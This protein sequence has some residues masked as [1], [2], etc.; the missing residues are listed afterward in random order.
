MSSTR[1]QRL[2]AAVLPP[3]PAADE[4]AGAVAPLHRL[5]GAADLRW[6]ARAGWH[7]TLAFLGNVDAELMPELCTRLAR[8]A[9]RTEAFPLR[10]RG[11]GRFDGRALWAGAEGGLG[12]L[13]LLAERT[14]AAARKSGIPMEEHR[15]HTP[16]L[17]LARSRA[18]A[19]LSPYTAALEGFEG[20]W[21]EA[22]ELGLVRSDLPVDGVPGE[23]PRYEVVRAWPLGR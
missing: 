5:P 22:G 6:T 4:L 11:G 20:I 10:I 17:T 12:T 16:H 18:Q 7:Y 15:R 8:A 3:G 9:R 2:F 14:S 23:Q 1:S 13:R 21:W 19:D